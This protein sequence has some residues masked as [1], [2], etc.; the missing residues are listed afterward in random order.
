MPLKQLSDEEV[1][2]RI[3]RSDSISEMLQRVVEYRYNDYT[4][5]AADMVELAS[6]KGLWSGRVVISFDN[7]RVD[8]RIEESESSRVK[9]PGALL[10]DPIFIFRLAQKDAF[11]KVFSQDQ[12]QEHKAFMETFTRLL[13][14]E[15]MMA[16]A[17]K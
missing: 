4:A 13:K 10:G 9:L 17:R 2:S 6:R 11:G 15:Q 16:G 1:V 14:K 7:G 5:L 12:V 3:A 8:R